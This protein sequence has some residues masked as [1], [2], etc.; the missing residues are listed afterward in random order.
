[1]TVKLDYDF[2]DAEG[3]ADTMQRISGALEQINKW[4]AGLH[5]ANLRGMVEAGLVNQASHTAGEAREVGDKI[6]A[7]LLKL[8][9][10]VGTASAES[11]VIT[12]LIRERYIEPITE[13]RN[14]SKA[15]A[16]GGLAV[17]H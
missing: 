8:I 13:H 16:S 9:D 11:D 12:F 15:G 1:M 6:H 2:R 5:E 4:N 14:Q 10:A 7:A 17:N 3:V